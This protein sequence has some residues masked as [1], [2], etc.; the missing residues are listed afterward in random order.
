MCAEVE[1]ELA[2]EIWG[3]VSGEDRSLKVKFLQ[4]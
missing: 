4:G 2:G 1:R 3:G